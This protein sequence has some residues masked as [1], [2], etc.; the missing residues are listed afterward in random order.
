MVDPNELESRIQSLPLW[1]QKLIWAQDVV[2]SRLRQDMQEIKIASAVLNGKG[3]FTIPGPKDE[4]LPPSGFRHLWVLYNDHP[5][6]LCSLG[7]NDLLLV[8]RDRKT[9]LMGIVAEED[10]RI[11]EN[12]GLDVIALDEYQGL[13]QDRRW[14]WALEREI[15]RIGADYGS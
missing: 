14:S 9:E 1:A 12:K 5:H 6:S 13:L 11:E 4:F 15:E 2:I 7:V 10:K 8:G 3:W